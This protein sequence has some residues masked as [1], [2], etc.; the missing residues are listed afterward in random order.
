MSPVKNNN[1]YYFSR[2]IAK[3]SGKTEDKR[4]DLT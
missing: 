3:K 4:D 2:T 1:Y